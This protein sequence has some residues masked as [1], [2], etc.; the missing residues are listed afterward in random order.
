MCLLVIEKK[1]K[2]KKKKNYFIGLLIVV[3]DIIL[4]YVFSSILLKKIKVL[5]YK[6]YLNYSLVFL[7]FVFLAV[8]IWNMKN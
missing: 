7:C 5:I 3:V 4:K 6:V 8:K 1:K 2:K